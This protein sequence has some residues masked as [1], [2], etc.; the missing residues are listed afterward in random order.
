MSSETSSIATSSPAALS[1]SQRRF[2]SAEVM[3]NVLLVEARDR[4]VVEHLAGGVAPGRVQ[5]LA[6]T[7]RGDVARDDAIEQARRVAPA[8]AVLVERRDVEQRRRAADRVVLALVRELVRA[9]D[10]VARPAPPRMAHAQ[11][12]GARVK[13]RRSQH[14][15]KN[16]RPC[17]VQAVLSAFSPRAGQITLASVLA[18]G[19]KP[20]SES[21]L[22]DVELHYEE[23]GQRRAGAADPRLRREHVFVAA[24]RAG[25]RGPLPRRADRPQGFRQ[26]TQAGRLGVFDP[27]PGAPRRALHPEARPRPRHRRAATRSAAASRWCSHSGFRATRDTR[28]GG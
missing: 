7:A 18:A 27:R 15:G 23:H 8:D 20:M 10:D 9:R 16:K 4:A 22:E 3:R 12:G 28:R 14:E 17:P 19:Q 25:A 21:N 11:R 26:L 24:P 2:G 5:D 6:D 1:S 13:R